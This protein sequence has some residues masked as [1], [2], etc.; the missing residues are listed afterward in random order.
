[1]KAFNFWIRIYI[2]LSSSFLLYFYVNIYNKYLLLIWY[3]QT[4]ALLSG[5][6]K[7]YKQIE[8][9]KY[10]SLLSLILLYHILTVVSVTETTEIYTLWILI[11]ANNLKILFVRIKFSR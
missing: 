3:L 11:N 9:I 8:I 1:M 2:S 7:H 10:F 4:N 6:I 5:N